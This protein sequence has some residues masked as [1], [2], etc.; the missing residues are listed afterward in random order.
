MKSAAFAFERPDSVQQALSLKA[1]WGAAARFLAGGQSLMPAMALRFS[2]SQCLIDLNGLD[3]LARISLQGQQLVIGAMARHAKVIASAE[4]ARAAPVLPKAGR[5]LAHAAIRN[6][7][8]FGGSL[9]L[10]DPAAEW[11][12]A[13]LLLDA[14][15]RILGERG[16]REV[17]VSQFLQ[18]M[19]TTALEEDE[20]VESV[21]IT[22]RPA[23][24]RSCVL[25]LARR[26]GDFATAAVMGSARVQ[27]GK[28]SG[29]RLVFF[30]VADTPLLDA[31]LNARLQDAF[32]RSGAD[33]V[34]AQAAKGVAAHNLRA[35]LYAQAATKAHL[36]GV[37]AARALAQLAAS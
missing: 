25:E 34:A 33:G 7:G 1:R 30:A 36:C 20:L 6:R 16:R 14:T 24:E 13:C 11:P 10:A 32:N 12:A 37:L 28:L 31:E 9:A 5:Y 27:D 21:V 8:T 35:D 18:G 17:P 29:L 19:Y 2:E 4:V 15:V 22:P 23:D 3:D 26:H